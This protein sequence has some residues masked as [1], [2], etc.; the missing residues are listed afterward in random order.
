M[1]M[2]Y[3]V[4]KEEVTTENEQRNQRLDFEYVGVFKNILS[5]IFLCRHQP[6]RFTQPIQLPIQGEY[7]LNPIKFF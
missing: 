1:I 7:R 4:S 6:M 5:E 2:W 3:V